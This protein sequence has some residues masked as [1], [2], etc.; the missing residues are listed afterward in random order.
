MNSTPRN[1]LSQSTLF[2]C[3]LPP[4]LE[5]PSITHVI[6]S[7]KEQLSTRIIKVPTLSLNSTFE[8]IGS[9]SAIELDTRLRSQESLRLLGANQSKNISQHYKLYCTVHRLH[10]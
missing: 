8:L 6:C 2:D 4:H 9:S 1:F 3:V 5:P 7:L 10:Q